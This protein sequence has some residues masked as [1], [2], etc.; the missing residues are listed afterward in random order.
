MGGP[1]KTETKPEVLLA[2]VFLDEIGVVINPQALR[3]LIRSR[4][5]RIS[6]LA[7]NIHGSEATPSQRIPTK[8]ELERL[9]QCGLAEKIGE[10]RYTV[11]AETLAD[12]RRQGTQ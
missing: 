8:D 9:V 12:Y 4:W 11:K 2:Q 3:V 6:A 5:D 10:D 1:Y 7:H